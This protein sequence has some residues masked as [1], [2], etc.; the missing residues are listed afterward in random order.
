VP[1]TAPVC[2]FPAVRLLSSTTRTHCRLRLRARWSR[3]WRGSHLPRR[4]SLPRRR[5]CDL[6]GAP[7]RR[8]R[9]P[10]S[11]SYSVAG[12]KLQR[13]SGCV[14]PGTRARA[15]SE[16][17]RCSLTATRSSRH[18]C[19]FGTA[20]SYQTTSQFGPERCATVGVRTEKPFKHEANDVLWTTPPNGVQAGRWLLSRC[21]NL[22]VGCPRSA[23]S[24]FVGPE[25]SPCLPR[26]MSLFV[27]MLT[28][29]V[30]PQGG[31]E[32]GEHTLARGD[33]PSTTPCSRQSKAGTADNRKVRE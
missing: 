4:S 28:L 1:S 17:I 29:N 2:G 33:I 26:P 3:R 6:P 19:T 18:A 8:W 16:A 31:E 22:E 32:Y 9:V 14:Q 13:C 12:L 27:G 30:A 5:W 7:G 11:R 23:T 25:L 15:L 21:E 20:R 10:D 24:K